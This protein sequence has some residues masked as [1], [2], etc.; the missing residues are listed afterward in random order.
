LRSIESNLNR[1]LETEVACK[2]NNKL[3]NINCEKSILLIANNGRQ[4]FKN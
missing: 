1:L 2:L 4:Y 3:A